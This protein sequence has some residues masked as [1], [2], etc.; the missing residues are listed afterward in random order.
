MKDRNHEKFIMNNERYL[1]IIN[2]HVNNISM[3]EYDETPHYM[4]IIL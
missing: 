1:S 2:N 4:E 3:E